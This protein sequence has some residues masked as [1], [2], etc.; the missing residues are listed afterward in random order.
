MQF[1]SL[2][3]L[4]SQIIRCPE[5]GKEFYD[6]GEAFP[7]DC[8]NGLGNEYTYKITEEVDDQ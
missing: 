5:C 1:N 7:C 3:Q 4:A 6:I 8:G 2:D